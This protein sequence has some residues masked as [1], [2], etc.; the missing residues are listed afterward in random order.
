VSPECVR[1]GTGATAPL[2]LRAAA[3]LARVW[4]KQGK[5]DAARALLA[6]IYEWFTEGFD[7]QDLKDA[8]ALLDE[9]M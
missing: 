2:E 9:L 5:K 7:T 1:V 8:K 6:P 3:S 4:G